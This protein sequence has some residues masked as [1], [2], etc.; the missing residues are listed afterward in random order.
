MKFES[1]AA[2][3]VLVR[4]NFQIP[5]L[6]F[7]VLFFVGAFL[8]LSIGTLYMCLYVRPG[9]SLHKQGIFKK[10]A[11]IVDTSI[12]SSSVL[13]LS[14]LVVK[15]NLLFSFLFQFIVQNIDF[16]FISFFFPCK[17]SGQAQTRCQVCCNATLLTIHL[18]FCC[19]G[20][21]DC[22]TFLQIFFTKQVAIIINAL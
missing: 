16:F 20:F 6:F 15:Q 17:K 8:S 5:V 9:S 7:Y 21:T 10:A 1:S 2:Q 22:T 13:S 3:E 4:R 14:S 12:Q 11:T 19:Q 18:S